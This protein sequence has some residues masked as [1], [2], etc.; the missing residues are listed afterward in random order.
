MRIAFVIMCS[1]L[2]VAA[3]WATLR[4]SAIGIR[5]F[6]K[7]DS[8]WRIVFKERPSYLGPIQKI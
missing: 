7:V 3:G 2:A 4:S 5:E 8:E 6:G 1:L